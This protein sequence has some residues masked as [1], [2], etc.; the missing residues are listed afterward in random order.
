MKRDMTKIYNKKSFVQGILILALG[1]LLFITDLINHS[2]EIK[3]AVLIFTLYFFGG[4]LLVRSLSRKLTKEDRLDQMDERNQLIEL[5]SKS[6]AFKLTQIISFAL[7]LV[8]LVIGKISGAESL[9][10]IAVGLA[11]AFA[12]SMLTEVFSFMYYES[13]N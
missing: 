8:L 10:A 6:K 2:F 7:M 11:F 1:T 4:G 13:K 5:E 9:I 12:I 3:G